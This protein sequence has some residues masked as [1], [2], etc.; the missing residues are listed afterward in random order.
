MLAQSWLSLCVAGVSP[1]LLRA[2][3]LPTRGLGDFLVPLCP[4]L[5]VHVTE[6]GGPKVATQGENTKGTDTADI[7]LNYPFHTVHGVVRARILE[8]VAISFS[9]KTLETPL[10]FKGIQPVNPQGSQPLEG[11]ILKLKLQSF[12]T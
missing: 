2:Q 6:T 9:E 4:S 10:D 11:L 5:P 1:S 7:P 3:G 8:W 12:A